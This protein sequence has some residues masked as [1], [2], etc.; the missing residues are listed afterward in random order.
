[1]DKEKSFIGCITGCAV[2]DSLGLSFEGLSEKRI[3]KMF[4]TINSIILNKIKGNYNV[5]KIKRAFN[6]RVKQH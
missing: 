5:W 2:G 1:M 6:Y 3:K 4:K